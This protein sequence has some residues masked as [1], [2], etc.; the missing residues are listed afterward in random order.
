MSVYEIFFGNDRYKYIIKGLEF[1]LAVTVLS[2]V[3]GIL[4][5]ILIASLRLSNDF[6]SES[7]YKRFMK[8]NPLVKLA[9]IY[10]DIIRGTPVM[11][12]LMIVSL[13]FVGPLRDTPRLVIASIAFGINSGA[14][15]SEIIRSGIQGLDKGQVEA[16]RA[17]GMPYGMTMKNIILPQ[18]IKNTLPTLVSEFIILLKE[19]SV[20]GFIGGFDLLRSADIITSQTYRG[21]PPLIVV[22]IIYFIL[23]STFTFFMRKVERRLAQ[24]D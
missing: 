23:T 24:N 8:Y 2:C 18:A 16:S 17:L 7:K 5:G 3:I 14:Y 9:T 13:I 4:M 19:T 15:V 1:S 10:V 21:W 22:A 11:V 6:L 12:Q 20:A